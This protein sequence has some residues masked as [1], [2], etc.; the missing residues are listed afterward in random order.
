MRSTEPCSYRAAVTLEQIL[1][2]REGDVIGF[3]VPE[4]MVAEVDGVP[5]IECRCGVLNGQY[6]VRVE[7]MVSHAAD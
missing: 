1:N 5:I 4:T 3:D 6:A 2:M 7:R